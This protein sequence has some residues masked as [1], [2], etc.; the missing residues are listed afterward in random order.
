MGRRGAIR[1]RCCPTTSRRLTMLF[2][3]Q[4]HAHMARALQLA[5]RGLFTTDP[6]P[7]VGCIIVGPDGSTIAEGWHERAGEG[8]AEVRALIGAGT[9]AKGATVYV[10]LEPCSHHGRTAPCADAL[11]SADVARVVCAIQDPN[12]QVAGEGINKLSAA[13]IEVQFGLL[14]AEAR[15]LNRG[16][17]M[18][19]EQQRP[20]VRAKLAVS[21]DG[22]TAMATGESKWITGAEARAD[23]HRLRAASAAILTGSGTVLAD[24]P[25]LNARGVMAKVKQPLRLVVDSSLRVQAGA[26]VFSADEPTRIYHVNGS[27]D[28]VARLEAA[29]AVVVQMPGVDGQVDLQAVMQDLAELQINDVLVEAGP[30]LNGGLLAAGLLDE[31]VVYQAAKIMGANARGMFALSAIETM[32]DS[33]EL[34]LVETRRVGNDLRLTYRNNN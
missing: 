23:V 18:R 27:A 6:N 20:W 26:K 29:G 11:I 1:C 28:N 19:M 33:I 25:Q 14:E 22:R 2:T 34:D 16:F 32:S 7:N 10:T 15:E 17:V 12:P 8:H 21:L 3:S 4:D 5:Q 30:V 24:D 31:L 13:G 9:K